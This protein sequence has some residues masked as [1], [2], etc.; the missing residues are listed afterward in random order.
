MLE[1]LPHA[2]CPKRTS[3]PTQQTLWKPE[4]KSVWQTMLK[5]NPSDN[6]WSTPKQDTDGEEWMDH[7]N[8]DSGG[9]RI[10]GRIMDDNG[11]FY[12]EAG[13][14]HNQAERIIKGFILHAVTVIT[15]LCFPL[16]N[17]NSLEN[18]LIAFKVQC[19][20]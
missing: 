4:A 19:I 6:R 12:Q 2:A 1:R 20:C 3:Q 5:G 14:K 11:L 7:R 10:M 18:P 8:K 17:D 15:H 9:G 13:N 16:Y